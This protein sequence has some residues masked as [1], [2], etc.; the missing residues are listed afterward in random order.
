MNVILASGSPRRK[1]LLGLIYDEFEVITADVDETVPQGMNVYD[2]PQYLAQLKC[3]ALAI[4]H[5][6]SVVIGADTVVI[7]DGEIFGKPH[8]E[9]DAKNMLRRLSGKA[10]DVV[11][12]CCVM[13]NGEQIKFSEKTRV[14]FHELTEKEI[15]NYVLTGEPNDK[16]GA[17]GI[18]GK[19]ALLVDRIDGDFYNVVGLP[20][21]VFYQI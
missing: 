16:A 4:N 1:E 5:S 21:Q 20:T 3:G 17:Y 8:D 12:G 15:D 6:D 9:N 19:G 13:M 11:T 10:H 14:F 7:C 2:V 18:Q